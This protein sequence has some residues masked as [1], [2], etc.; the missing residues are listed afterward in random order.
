MRRYHAKHDLK[1]PP[2][3]GLRPRSKHAAKHDL[4]R[5]AKHRPT[6]LY[7]LGATILLI[8]LVGTV[9]AYMLKATDTKTNLFTPAVVSCEVQEITDPQVTEKSSIKVRNTG[10][11]EA[12]IRLR[13]VSY[14]VRTS[15]DGKA[16]I[17]SM[18]SEMPEINLTPDWVKGENDTY[19]CR[20]PIAPGELTDELLA[21]NITLSE[22]DGCQQVIEVFAE[23]IQSRPA[24][25]VSQSWNIT[26]DADG[27]IES[28]NK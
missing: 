2:K 11:I 1:R 24:E 4:E 26:L 13:F 25:A 12:Y 9:L 10:N 8:A 18:P 22:K 16:Q 3:Q 28:I 17:T 6:A 27:K 14:W 15:D 20:S 21:S 7:A 19:Y 23:A 5:P